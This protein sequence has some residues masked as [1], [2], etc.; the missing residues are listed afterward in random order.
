MSVYIESPWRLLYNVQTPLQTYADCVRVLHF[1]ED[2][3]VGLMETE[4][5]C[6]LSGKQS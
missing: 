4:R 6:L 3:V 2:L 5:K 1:G